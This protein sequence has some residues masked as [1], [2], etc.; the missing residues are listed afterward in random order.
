MMGS[1]A[2]MF[3]ILAMSNNI[4]DYDVMKTCL[5]AHNLE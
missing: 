3:M 1:I 4:I 2:V 5:M